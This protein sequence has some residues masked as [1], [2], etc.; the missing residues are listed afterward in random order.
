LVK[1][2]LK[3]LLLFIKLHHVVVVVLPYEPV[4]IGVFVES[5][6]RHPLVLVLVEQCEQHILEL[7][8]Q[9]DFVQI[10]SQFLVFDQVIEVF[11]LALVGV[12]EAR[13][14]EHE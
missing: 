1:T 8:A 2:L 14:A 13:V 4:D 9:L 10:G 11:V 6:Q 12:F 5:F 7:C 3:L